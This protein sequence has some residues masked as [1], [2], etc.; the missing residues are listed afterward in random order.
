ME[1]DIKEKYKKYIDNY[2]SIGKLVL[3]DQIKA[4]GMDNEAR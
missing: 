1:D 2:E 4:E 3:E